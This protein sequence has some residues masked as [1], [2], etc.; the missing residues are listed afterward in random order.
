MQRQLVLD[1]DGLFR[2]PLDRLFHAGTI[3]FAR[4]FIEHIEVVVIADLKDV[5]SDCHAYGIRLA[6]VV[7]HNDLHI[8]LSYFDAPKRDDLVTMVYRP[9]TSP[10]RMPVERYVVAMTAVLSSRIKALDARIQRDI[11]DEVVPTAQAA[12]GLNGEIV[13]SKSYGETDESNRYAMFS[14]TKALIA[15]VIWQLIDE[16]RLDV[17]QPVATYFP[18]FAKN[19]K[20]AVTVE[21]LLTHTGGFP[22]A[23]MSGAHWITREARQERMASWRL[24]FE[25]GSQFE[26]HPTAGHWVLGEVIEALDG[27]EASESVRSRILDPLGLQHA[28]VGAAPDRQSDIMDLTVTGEFPTPDELEAV[29]GVREFDM[30][31][32]TPEI[33][34][35]MNEPAV[36]SSAMPGGG[37]FSNAEDMAMLYQS[38]L[39]NSPTLW[40]DE[41]LQRGTSEVLVTLPDP[42]FGYPSNRTLGLISAGDDGLAMMRGMGKT[43]SARSFGHNGAGG[44]IAFA[45]PESGLSFCYL[46]NGIDLHFLRQAG[47]VTALASL[48]GLVTTPE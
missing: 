24:S 14:C 4:L 41:V 40:S 25:P 33:L 8:T 9:R 38:F 7:I 20:E 2:A 1:R 48:G 13:W 16:G 45:D 29:A 34:L 21:H 3:L 6:E 5:R 10:R 11:D 47:R 46:T 32:V 37:G 42:M 18:D 44:Q 43:A 35:N 12:I 26:Y 39:H 15:G 17:S 19:G 30:G 22:H 28:T 23:P 31:E 27:V 36:R